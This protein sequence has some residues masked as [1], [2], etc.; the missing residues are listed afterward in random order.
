MTTAEELVLDCMKHR[1]C[2]VRAASYEVAPQNW[3]P[4]ACVW[5]RT[6]SGLRRMWIHSFAHCLG[7]EKLTFN[8]KLD[9][10]H[11][12]LVAARTIVDRALDEAEENNI[13]N[14]GDI[15]EP[16]RRMWRVALGSI[17]G[18]GHFKLFRQ[19]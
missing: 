14:A 13:S 4:E 10:D 11:W 18:I 1:G 15:S 9:A 2:G 8:N 3:L 19:H 7:A 6:E 12:A 17:R 5:L 16:K